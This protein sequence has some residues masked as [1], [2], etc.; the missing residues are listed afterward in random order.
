[1]STMTSGYE[2]SRNILDCYIAGFTYYD[3]ISVFDDLS[4][5]T[6]VALRAEPDN[7][8]DPNAVAVFYGNSKLGYIPRNTN[9]LISD[10]LYFGYGEIMEALISTRD[11]YAQPEKQFRVVIR[12]IDK[13]LR[14]QPF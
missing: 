2:R 8:Y 4:I 1:M 13:R 11:I 12:L 6:S 5:G 3:G 9:K 10:L 7:P 14:V